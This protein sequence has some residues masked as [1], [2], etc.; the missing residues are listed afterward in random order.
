MNPLFEIIF[1]M[2]VAELILLAFLVAP[3][4]SSVRAPIVRWL[5]S[6]SLV[7]SLVRPLSYFFGTP[8]S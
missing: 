1:A 5:S 7:V 6:S 2:L 4:P 8:S 3:L